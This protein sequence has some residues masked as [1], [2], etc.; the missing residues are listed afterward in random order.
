MSAT[1]NKLAAANKV[2]DDN[3]ALDALRARNAAD[4]ESWHNFLDLQ[5][6]LTIELGR[7]VMTAREVLN[8]DTDSIIQLQRSTGEGMDVLAG[9]HRIARA[10]VIMIEERTGLRINEIIIPEDR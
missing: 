9:I 7:T 1:A 6:A 5:V 8:L 4:I 3:A 10:E 2:L